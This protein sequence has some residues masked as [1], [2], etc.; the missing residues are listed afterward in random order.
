MN[1]F[2][3]LLFSG[4]CAAWSLG[5][6]ANPQIQSWTTAKGGKVLFVEAPELPM[7]DV[8]VI[9][10]AGSARDADKPGVS[11]LML[12]LVDK[13]ADGLDAGEIARG[14][15]DRGSSI[16]GASER[17]LAWL[18][19]RSL[20]D[21][22]LLQPSLELFAKVLQKPDFPEKDF[23]REQKRTLIS[24]QYQQ[25]KPGSIVSKDFYRGVY[26]GHPYASD[27]VGT[28]ESVKAL[29][30]DDLRK[31]YQRYFVA[32]N[33]TL[34]IVGDISRA[35]AETIAA[36]LIDALPQ[37]KSAPAIAKVTA[38][39]SPED[40]FVQHPSSQSHVL[41]GAPGM[42]R[43]DPDY[44]SLYVGNHILGGSGLV[45]RISDEIREQRGLAYSAYS[46][47]VPMKQDGPFILGFQTRNDQRDQA[48]QVLRE[49]LQ[50]FIDAGPSEKELK[51][52]KNN[53]IGGFPLRA[54]SNSKIIEYLAVIG[55]YNL[56]LDYLDRFP[57]K[58]EAVT[59]ESIKSAFQRR[60]DAEKMVTVIV[61]ESIDTKP[62]S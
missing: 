61:G 38:L 9:F 45:S 32:R 42:H 58:V 51:A 40:I 14:F 16:S 30:S 5:V 43:G 4:L 36:Q 37:G 6:Q 17:D 11:Q 46:Y 35:Q 20:T 13:G 50:T 19:L 49:T 53:I 10:D 56:P 1:V 28:V 55:F 48:L 47:F 41:M 39:T 27:P 57:G 44:F 31:F 2:R 26:G 52:S 23:Q 60:V 54:S 24:I 8:R 7:V 3:I 21:E 25:Q 59:V 18:S 34:A 12:G 62:G 15:E 29:K 22:K 33:A